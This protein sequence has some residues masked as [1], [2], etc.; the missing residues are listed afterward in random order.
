MRKYRVLDLFA[1]G[2]GFSTGF[3]DASYSGYQFDIVKAIDIDE[4]ACATLSRH[5]GP[6]K[7]IH[8]DITD[9]KV[10]EQLIRE[11]QGVDVIIGGPPCQTFSLAGPARS[12]SQEMREALKNDP[13]NVLY[14][15]F[16]EI[17]NALRPRFVVFENVLGIVSKSVDAPNDE[18]ISSKDKL[19][20]EAICD[21]LHLMGY[22]AH[23]EGSITD[24]YQILN[25]ADYGVPQQRKRVIIIANRCNV[26]NPVPEKTHGVG[27]KPYRTLKDAIE[28]LP[29]VLPEINLSRFDTLKN[30]SV[31]EQNLGKSM[32]IFVE[33]IKSLTKI[34]NDRQE[35]QGQEFTELLNYIN[36]EC[37]RIKNKKTW[38]MKELKS[39]I[40]GY[41]QRLGKLNRSDNIAS[42]TTL[43]VSRQ[44]NFRDIII[45]MHM[46]AGSNSARFMNKQSDDYDPFLDQLYPY[47]RNKHKD[48]Y[49]KHAWDK[50][51]NTILAHMEKDGLKFIHPVQ[52]RSFTPYEAALL[53][54]FPED[55]EFCGNA[56]AQYRQIG[57]AVPPKLAKSIGD[58]LLKILVQCEQNRQVNGKLKSFSA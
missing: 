6:E 34:Y 21:E 46:K 25:A 47:A 4:D 35:V 16:L 1:G 33:G 3:L 32:D 10:K 11:C 30:L 58:A 50:P 49:V 38:K 54:S 8:G 37:K 2:G 57:N 51:S 12:G 42:A 17:V 48:T 45:F 19:V 41:N 18:S 31:I 27:L 52:P 44:H 24:R 15:H 53:Q 39:F 26:S 22:N 14:K 40:Q 43:H 23:I 28:D 36:G 7:V 56:N 13:R 5:L 29:V 9:K 20:I 55:Y